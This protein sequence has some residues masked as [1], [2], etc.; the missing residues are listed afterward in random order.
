MMKKAVKIFYI[1]FSLTLLFYVALP[2]FGFPKPPSDSVQ[3]S[4]PADTETPLRRA[5]FTNLSRA[6]V[7]NWYENQFKE[8]RFLN[9]PMPTFLLNYPPEES[10]AIIRDQTRSTFLEEVVNPFRE[11]MFIN[12][13]EP[14]ENDDENRI[15][16][17][18]VHWRQKI[19]VRYIPTNVAIRSVVMLLTLLAI[20]V[21][22]KAFEL[23]FTSL[24]EFIQRRRIGKRK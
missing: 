24:K 18:G 3:S 10:Q 15:I 1:L 4:E 5:Y 13:Y 22:V 17:N 19:I 7:L 14:K 12:G 16:I 20:P 6:D 8:S 9:I 23:E 2:N 21:L 11:T